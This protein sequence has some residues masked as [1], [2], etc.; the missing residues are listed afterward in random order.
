[1]IKVQEIDPGNHKIYIYS[2][3]YIYTYTNMS[4]RVSIIN[5]FYFHLNINEPNM[6]IYYINVKSWEVDFLQS[7][8]LRSVREQKRV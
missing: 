4:T 8:E 3:I 2:P 1:M 5:Y 7:I 6:Y